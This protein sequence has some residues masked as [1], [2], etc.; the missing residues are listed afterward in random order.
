MNHSEYLFTDKHIPALFYHP[1]HLYW[2]Y[3][4]KLSS[5]AFISALPKYAEETLR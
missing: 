2:L 5:A 1:A 3:I 4:A